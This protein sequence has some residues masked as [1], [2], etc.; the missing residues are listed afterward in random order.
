MNRPRV[1]AR[2]RRHQRGQVLVI[3]ALTVPLLIGAAALAVN[4]GAQST[5]HRMLQNWTDAGALAGARECDTSCNAKTEVTSALQIVLQNSPWSASATWMTSAPTGSCTA[6]TCTV[7]NYAG[8]AGYTNYQ[9]SASSPP[10]HP[11]N[12]SY[13]TTNYVEVDATETASSTFG[14]F[15]GVSALSW[16]SHSVAF[17]AGPNGLFEFAMFAKQSITSGNQQETVVGDAYVGGGY[18]GTGSKS[19]LC[20]LEVP[21]TSASDTDGDVGASQDNDQDDQ[22]HAVYNVV[23]PSVGP[24]PTYGGSYTRATCPKG[25][26]ISLNQTAPQSTPPT[27]CPVGASPHSYVSGGTTYWVCYEAT[28]SVPNVPAPTTTKASLCGAGGSATVNSSTAAGVYP[29]GAGCTVTLDFTSGNINCVSLVLGAGAAVKTQSSGNY[30]MS[31][32][33]SD[34]TVADDTVASTAITNL[35]QVPPLTP[36]SGSSNFY[37]RAVIWAPDTSTLPMPT[38]LT[39]AANGC[40]S[41]TLFVGNIFV[42]DQQVTYGPNQDIEN[43]G[44][45]YCGNWSVSSGNHPNPLASYDE[46]NSSYLLPNDRLVE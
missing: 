21:E 13:N 36:C 26:A 46:V 15:I 24:A 6:T 29:V 41:D 22:G 33:G 2:R 31:A 9:V 5:G 17:D 35:G 39:N 28:P 45:V 1:T 8:P 23:P 27:N 37:D 12:A 7:T 44:G 34:P 20:I 32:Y 42:P 43:I 19:G 38:V 3:F 30:Y 10:A 11:T 4:L 40:C 16:S 25:G 18:S 14:A